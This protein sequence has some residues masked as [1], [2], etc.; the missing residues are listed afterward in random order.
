MW[1]KE[2]SPASKSALEVMLIA[3]Y[4]VGVHV[5]ILAH[6]ALP[7]LP[8]LVY[9]AER[10]MTHEPKGARREKRTLDCVCFSTVYKSSVCQLSRMRIYRIR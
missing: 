10:L 3:L 5:A 4:D 8:A 9:S 6:G 2:S 7:A 1:P